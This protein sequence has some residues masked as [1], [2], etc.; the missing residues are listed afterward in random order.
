[1][2]L[3]EIIDKP[4]LDNYDIAAVLVSPVLAFPMNHNLFSH[5]TARVEM[6]ARGARLEDVALFLISEF[7]YGL[8]M[9]ILL[10]FQRFFALDCQK[11][12]A[13]R[14]RKRGVL[15]VQSIRR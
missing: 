15:R 7:Q 4:R 12:L 13:A 10:A 14:S 2:G 1:V 5:S 11:Q 9:A 6:P 8:K 3:R